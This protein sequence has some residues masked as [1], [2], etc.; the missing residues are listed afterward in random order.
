MKCC[1][2]EEKIKG[3][4]EEYHTGEIVGECCLND[5]EDLISCIDCGKLFLVGQDGNDLGFCE[6]CQNKDDFPY[7]LDAYYKNYDDDKVAFKGTDTRDRG[8]LEPYRKK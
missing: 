3:S 2:C 1:I 6:T 8:L 5:C 4:K 7:D